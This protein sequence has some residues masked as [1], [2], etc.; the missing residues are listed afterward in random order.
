MK[1]VY[2]L[3]FNKMKKRCNVL[4]FSLFAV[5]TVFVIKYS[6]FTNWFNLNFF[7]RPE[8]LPDVKLSLFTSF[9]VTTVFYFITNYLPDKEKE[10]KALVVCENNLSNIYT[11]M[12]EVISTMSLI[13]NI[14]DDDDKLDKKEKEIIRNIKIKKKQI[15]YKKIAYD[16]KNNIKRCEIEYINL[17][18]IL[19]TDS[20]KILKEVETIKKVPIFNSL[21]INLNI[22]ISN[23]GDSGLLKRLNE[24]IESTEILSDR[25]I[26]IEDAFNE[27][28][29][30][31][32]KLTKYRFDKQKN[33]YK[34]ATAE[35]IEKEKKRKT[36]REK[37]VSYY[38]NKQINDVLE[39]ICIHMSKIISNISKVVLLNDGKNSTINIKS[40][41][42]ILKENSEYVIEETTKMK[43]IMSTTVEVDAKQI[44][45]SIFD[46]ELLNILNNI[47][48]NDLTNELSKCSNI[49]N[50]VE[51]FKNAYLQLKNYLNDV[52]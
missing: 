51:E 38:L 11:Y 1:K 45:C 44:I 25:A 50:I 37:Q 43:M 12:S 15:W 31:Y 27:F 24:M 17:Y 49:D 29:V 48:E 36:E 26:I 40:L 8:E 42:L 14:Q 23:I 10:Y 2:K 39:V 19:K 3:V 9:V 18:S 33:K 35:E 7:N 52:S 5:S 41:Y 22:I 4:V 34:I 28:I 20:K 32:K 16:T 21:D 47:D 6:T 13:A 46:L 30:N